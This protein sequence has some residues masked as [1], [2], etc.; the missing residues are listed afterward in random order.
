MEVNT[1]EALAEADPNP[2]AT[3]ETST[4]NSDEEYA[5]DED[6]KSHRPRSMSSESI[7]TVMTFSAYE[8]DPEDEDHEEDET[9]ADFRLEDLQIPPPTPLPSANHTASTSQGTLAE[10]TAAPESPRP[11]HSR[12]HLKHMSA[13]LEEMRS[14]MRKPDLRHSRESGLGSSIHSSIAEEST[15]PVA[16]EEVKPAEEI[17]GRASLSDDSKEATAR[18][19]KELDNYLDQLNLDVMDL[20]QL[21]AE[22]VA[23]RDVNMVPNPPTDHWGRGSSRQSEYQWD[24]LQDPLSG[25]V[26]HLRA[27][28]SISSLSST[29]GSIGST[30]SIRSISHTQQYPY[31]PGF[32][33]PETSYRWH[34]PSPIS[35][36]IPSPIQ[37]IHTPSPTPPPPA[38]TQPQVTHMSDGDNDDELFD[39]KT[40]YSSNRKALRTLG[41]INETPAKGD[42][43][44]R[45]SRSMSEASLASD[46]SFQ[47]VFRR[48]ITPPPVPGMPGPSVSSFVKEQEGAGS[49]SARPASVVANAK[50]MRTLGISG[51]GEGGGGGGSRGTSAGGTGSAD[52]VGKDG[53]APTLLDVRSQAVVAGYLSKMSSKRLFRVSSWKRRYYVLTRSHIF[54]FKSNVETEEASGIMSLQGSEVFVATDPRFKGKAVLEIQSAG[55]SRT[56]FVLFENQD[57]LL[58]WLKELRGVISGQGLKGNLKNGNRTS[59]ANSEASSNRKSMVQLGTY[60]PESSS[61]APPPAIS[62]APSE[63]STNRM[64][65]LTS[66]S[67]IDLYVSPPTPPTPTSPTS[68]TSPTRRTLMNPSYAQSPPPTT[69]HTPRPYGYPYPSPIRRDSDSTFSTITSASSSIASTNLTSAYYPSTNRSDTTITSPTHYRPQ[70]RASNMNDYNAGN[71]GSQTTLRAMNAPSPIESAIAVLDMLERHEERRRSI[72]GS[73]E[74]G[75]RGSGDSGSGSGSGVCMVEMGGGKGSPRM[76]GGTRVAPGTGMGSPRWQTNP[77]RRNSTEK[78]TSWISGSSDLNSITEE[79]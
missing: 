73:P 13:T 3:S 41:I 10:T 29:G 54:C 44:V 11:T 45:R 37:Q 60:N 57:L 12:D 70:S 26:H 56:W 18:A 51:E 21:E 63:V 15:S 23:T 53:K 36:L 62:P 65:N 16:K 47:T 68:P 75:R 30:P 1:T 17:I 24:E 19:L 64:S 74:L 32:S 55:K 77:A 38:S 34:T 72:T 76:M 33:A 40:G 7:Q 28:S 46:H 69:N 67:S 49:A 66:N 61:N 5:W 2:V 35:H 9:S 39:Q 58:H 59:V 6:Y 25:L 50:A 31:P 48:S 22:L 27:T 79:E 78:R 8:N 42:K 43:V 20:E 4:I 71:N 14:V 52:L